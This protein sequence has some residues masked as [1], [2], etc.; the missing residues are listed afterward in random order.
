ML[1]NKCKTPPRSGKQ[2]R[3]RWYNHIDP[4]INKNQ[5][6]SKEE[7]DK[8]FE[9]HSLYGNKWALIAE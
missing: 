8:L 3:E 1:G 4:K 6:W 7:E 5:K 2:C 9:L